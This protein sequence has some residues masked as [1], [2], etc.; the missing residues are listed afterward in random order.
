MKNLKKAARG[1]A[2]NPA[3]RPACIVLANTGWWRR[4]YAR[5]QQWRL[6]SRT[7]KMLMSLNNTQLRDI[8]LTRSDLPYKD[9][10]R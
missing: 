1:N 10:R 9:Q 5:Y 7:R 2:H 8:G 4:I 6:H 3:T